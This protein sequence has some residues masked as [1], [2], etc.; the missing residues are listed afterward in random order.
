MV[1]IYSL[2]K[3]HHMTG[4]NCRIVINIWEK[5]RQIFSHHVFLSLINSSCNILIFLMM[6][7]WRYLLY[8]FTE[9]MLVI[10]NSEY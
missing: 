8:K 3:S 7:S 2:L 1:M 10:V 6:I 5:M 4:I 9:L